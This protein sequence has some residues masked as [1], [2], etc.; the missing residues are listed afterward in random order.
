[1]FNANELKISFHR[2]ESNLENFA[3]PGVCD[4]VEKLDIT[5]SK[6]IKDTAFV[7]A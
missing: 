4:T 2:S 6:K 5:M 7:E 3:F 1:M